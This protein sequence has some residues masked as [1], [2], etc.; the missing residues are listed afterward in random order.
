[1]ESG[2]YY[3]ICVCVC[4]CVCLYVALVMWHAMRMHLIVIYDLSGC[5]LF[6][7]L[8]DKPHAFEKKTRYRTSHLF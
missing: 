3:I 6:S 4:V 8:S 7:T 5:A 2:K 1:M